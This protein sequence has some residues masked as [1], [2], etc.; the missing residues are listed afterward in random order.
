V[1]VANHFFDNRPAWVPGAYDNG[2]GPGEHARWTVG[3]SLFSKFQRVFYPDRKVHDVP[4][5]L[6]SKSD[7]ITWMEENNY[8]MKLMF[9]EWHR[10]P[11]ED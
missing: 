2:G 3:D 1:I 5:F 6:A 7:A 10:L 8:D 11:G 9:A 4:S